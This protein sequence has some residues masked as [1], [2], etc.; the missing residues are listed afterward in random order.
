MLDEDIGMEGDEEANTEE[1]GDGQEGTG[2]DLGDRHILLMDKGALPFVTKYSN[3]HAGAPSEDYRR[4]G[5]QDYQA[6]LID[7]GP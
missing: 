7:G 5:W 4:S 3:P 2:G 1:G 6:Q